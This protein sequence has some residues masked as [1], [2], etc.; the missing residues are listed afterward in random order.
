[1]VSASGEPSR[2]SVVTTGTFLAVTSMMRTCPAAP[3]ADP[4]QK[5]CRQGARHAGAWR[6]DATQGA[7]A[8]GGIPAAQA[9]GDHPCWPPIAA[10]RGIW[11]NL[12][13]RHQ[14]AS[15]ASSPTSY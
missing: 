11:M 13:S 9:A 4:P 14:E 7:T 10:E 2:S 3:Q 12:G 8:G 15:A 1:M 6:T 5:T